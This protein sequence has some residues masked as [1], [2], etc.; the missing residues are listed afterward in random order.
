MGNPFTDVSHDLLVLDTKEIASEK[1]VETVK[2]I[3]KV[4]MQQ[5]NS[6]VE[7]RVI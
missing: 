2:E 4:G 5:F 6:F 1:V 7:E 3:E